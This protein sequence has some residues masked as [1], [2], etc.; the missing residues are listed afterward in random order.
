VLIDGRFRAACFLTVLFR[1]TRPVTVYFDDYTDRPGYH[2]I[3]R[4]GAPV[5]TFGRMAR[6]DVVPQTLP[7]ADLSFIMDVY[8][9]KA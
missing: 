4:Y 8:A 2:D 7:V 3:E 9:R 1:A 6:F 5:A